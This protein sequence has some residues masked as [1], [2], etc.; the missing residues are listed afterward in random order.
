MG[1]VKIEMEFE[2]RSS[3]NILFNHIGTA[4]GLEEW[5]ADKV[6][7]KGKNSYSFFWD[8]K[9]EAAE[10]VKKTPKLYTKTC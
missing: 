8:G 10:L 3:P 6:N 9:E 2:V 4:S 5:F 1:R 7:V